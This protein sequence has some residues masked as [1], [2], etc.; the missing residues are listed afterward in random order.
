MA[1]QTGE[2]RLEE[3]A[4]E[5]ARE[6][7][8]TALPEAFQN[9]D[10]VRRQCFPR[11]VCDISLHGLADWMFVAAN[12]ALLVYDYIRLHRQA[13]LL[14]EN[15]PRPA[16]EQLVGDVRKA[17]QAAGIEEP[18]LGALCAELARVLSKKRSVELRA[19]LE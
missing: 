17:G 7:F 15:N 9:F 6:V 16:I 13:L 12:F 5:I 18:Q 3:F 11:G 1:K 2:E 4:C 8:Q 14:V 10:S 19:W